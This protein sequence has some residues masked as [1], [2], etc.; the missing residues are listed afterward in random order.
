MSC[1]KSGLEPPPQRP[2]AA[3]INSLTSSGR[4]GTTYTTPDQPKNK[5]SSSSLERAAYAEQA[6]GGS[7]HNVPAIRQTRDISPVYPLREDGLSK[8]KSSHFGFHRTTKQQPPGKGKLT[9]TVLRRK[10]SSISQYASSNPRLNFGA[11]RSPPPAWSNGSLA[12]YGNIPDSMTSMIVEVGNDNNTTLPAPRIVPELDRSRHAVP[13]RSSKEKLA[14]K[15][16]HKLSTHDLPP[17]TPVYS[18]Q[19]GQ[20]RQSSGHSISP[21]TQFSESSG[22]APYSRNTTPNSVSSQ[23]PGIVSPIKSSSRITYG[24]PSRTRPPVTRRC[25]ESDPD[26]DPVGPRGL[27]S[28]RESLTSSSSGSTVKDNEKGKRREKQ[29]R[30]SP[31]PPSPPPRKS[32]QRVRMAREQEAVSGPTISSTLG[33]GN[34]LAALKYAA[35][36]QMMGRSSTAPPMRPS[37]EGT[38]DLSAH[39]AQLSESMAVVHSNLYAL[40]NSANSSAKFTAGPLSRSESS[41]PLNI[42]QAARP[43]LSSRIPSRRYSPN[44]AP[45]KT[46]EATSQPMNLGTVQDLRPKEGAQPERRLRSPSPSAKRFGFLNPPRTATEPSTPRAG[47]EKKIP[48]R[49]PQAGTGHEGY[50]RHAFRSRSSSFAAAETSRDRLVSMARPSFDSHN[51]KTTKD[52]FFLQRMSPV[53]IAG[54]GKIIENQNTSTKLDRTESATSSFAAGSLSPQMSLSKDE[55]T[56]TTLLPSALPTNSVNKPMSAYPLPSVTKDSQA[57]SLSESSEKEVKPT[58][59]LRRSMQRLKHVDQEP[60]KLPQPIKVTSRGTSPVI[61]SHDPSM[62]SL[63]SFDEIPWG[64]IGLRRVAK[65]KILEKPA[66]QPRSPRK[67]KWNFFQRA[68]ADPE[69]PALPIASASAP[70]AVAHYAMMPMDEQEALEKAVALE[71]IMR[72]VAEAET[73]RVSLDGFA[74]GTSTS[75]NLRRQENVYQPALWWKYESPPDLRADVEK[76]RAQLEPQETTAMTKADNA[77]RPRLQHVGRIPRVAARPP[78]MS[79][80]SFSRPFVHTSMAEDLSN[81]EVEH[82][83]FLPSSE[84]KSSV[85]T[86]SSGSYSGLFSATENITAVAPDSQDPLEEDEVWDEYDDILVAL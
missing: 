64:N 68:K 55:T 17:P 63:S 33:A 31:P 10:P 45:Q 76:T 59:A 7:T 66:T 8:A 73:T 62:T 15:I 21:S 51:S 38:L 19:S 70:K 57:K 9:R 71:D 58:L 12:Q 85:V 11:E 1:H 80:K 32:S 24:S 29:K 53:V 67:Q 13:Y 28:L 75:E 27:P 77:V 4:H 41:T 61:S 65:P 36:A 83:D 5:R 14:S 16:P 23:S 56:T 69:I 35:D 6:A 74:L 48:K 78:Q 82:E 42:G 79:P 49:G 37:R 54:G 86:T 25:T 84:R 52:S 34:D 72:E 81:P 40:G 39:L 43:V 20:N 22:P 26:L 30:L 46:R 60:L 3:S 2:R 50:G 47:S 44:P 18:S